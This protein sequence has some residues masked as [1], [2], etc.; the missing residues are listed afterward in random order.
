M[1]CIKNVKNQTSDVFPISMILFGLWNHSKSSFLRLCSRYSR[2]EKK[3]KEENLPHVLIWA[4]GFSSI[5]VAP[6][7]ALDL[8]F[9]LAHPQPPLPLLTSWHCGSPEHF[10]VES[11]N[12]PINDWYAYYVFFFFIFLF[13]MTE[14]NQKQRHWLSD[15]DT[16]RRNDRIINFSKATELFNNPWKRTLSRSLS[17]SPLARSLSLFLKS[18]SCTALSMNIYVK[19]I[20]ISAASQ[21]YWR[22]IF[23]SQW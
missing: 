7:I 5:S 17:L 9:S 22:L 23:V 14:H 3:R 4:L 12:T 19:I 13:L 11:N 1:S 21:I 16:I 6:A 2:E 15:V 20:S 8:S 18:D 10:Y